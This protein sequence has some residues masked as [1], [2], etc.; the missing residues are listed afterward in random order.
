MMVNIPTKYFITAG[1]AEGWSPLNAF[2]NALL[3]SKVGNTNLVRMSS[4][5]PPQCQEVKDISFPYGALVPTAYASKVSQLPG[6]IISAA[7]AV[8]I[9]KDSTKPGVI[10][11]YSAS[12]H[13]EEAEEIVKNMAIEAMKSRNEEI[14]EIKVKSTSHKVEHTGAVFACCVLWY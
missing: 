7:I 2:D 3:N 9:P 12:S 14:K 1:S 10:M 4:I 6:E 8:A 11:E 13:K 5:I